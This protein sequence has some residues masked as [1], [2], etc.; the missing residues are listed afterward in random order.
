MSTIA[1]KVVDSD[2]IWATL[3]TND[4]YL[5][6]L[7]TLEFSLRRV[8]SKYPLVAL[9]TGSL[10]PKTLH[11]LTA[12][13]I[14]TQQV[15]YLLPGP[16]SPPSPPPSPPDSQASSPVRASH[17]TL[18]GNTTTT[19]TTK[20]GGGNDKE[21][22]WYANDPRFRACFTK[23]AVFSLTGYARIVLLDA[24]ML[25]RRNMDELFDLPLAA[26]PTPSHSPLP[27]SNNNNTEETPGP[28]F[29]AT[30]ACLCNPLHFAHYPPSWTPSNCA[31]TAQHP[32]PDLAQTTAAPPSSGLGLLNGGLLCVTPSARAYS[33]ILAFLADPRR[34]TP[35]ALPFADQSLLSIVFEGRWAALPYVYN[36]LKTMRWERVHGRIWRDGEVKCVHYILTPKPWE[37]K[38]GTQQKG[39]GGM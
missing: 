28:I 30:H 12:R 18:T 16:P 36:A 17:P 27:S 24:D 32:H 1:T 29:A 9:H 35:A 38:G 4:S 20:N 3:I 6:G 23:L 39:E 34:A 13:G 14:P 19:T 11:A 26:P 25:V 21:S 31:F 2:K 8:G 22:G 15:P 5:P 33:Q 7:L 10:P 37:V